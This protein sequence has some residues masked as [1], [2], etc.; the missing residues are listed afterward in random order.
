MSSLNGGLDQ[1]DAECFG[2]LVFPTIRKGVGLKG[3]N[4]D[5]YLGTVSQNRILSRVNSSPQTLPSFRL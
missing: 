5:N 4:F 3:L 2:R 1:Y